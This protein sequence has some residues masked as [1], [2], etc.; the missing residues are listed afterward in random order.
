MLEVTAAELDAWLAAALFPLAR[1]LG[2]F[3]SAPVF[4]NRG[5]PARIRLTIGLVVGVAILPVVGPMP[6][7]RPASGIGLL[8]LAQQV[9]IGLAIGFMMRL[10]FAAADLAG[11]LIAMQMGLSFAIFF[12]PDAGGQTG[13]VS[14]FLGLFIT[15]LFL[16][17]NGHLLLIDIMVHSFSWLPVSERPFSAQGWAYILQ[18]GGAI[19]S[20]GL[21]LSLPVIGILLLV[22][23]AVGAL[24]RASPQLNLLAVGFP[25]TLTAG[26]IGL[27]LLMTHFAPAVQLLFE[28]GMDDIGQLLYW[29]APPPSNP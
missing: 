13:V 4:S 26:F 11:A 5:V 6:E 17:V 25:I 28:R 2:L 7:V 27:L 22:N 18:A 14:D 15:L 23:L 16:A 19:F 1:V 21:L 29:L 24:T 3:A 10:V 9:V 20:T 8:I 12:D